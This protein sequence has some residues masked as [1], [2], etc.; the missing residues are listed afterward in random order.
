MKIKGDALI[1]RQR[2]C[3]DKTPYDHPVKATNAAYNLEQIRAV[4]F[5]IYRCRYCNFYH[6]GREKDRHMFDFQ[7]A[8]ATL[9]PHPIQ[10]WRGR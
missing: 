4:R 6:I 7:Y 5:E 9:H 8:G 10:V 3:G 2:S 1:D